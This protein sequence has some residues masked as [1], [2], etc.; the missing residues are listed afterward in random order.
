MAEWCNQ[1]LTRSK[2]SCARHDQR[3]FSHQ[4]PSLMRNVMKGSSYCTLQE[5]VCQT[6]LFSIPDKASNLHQ[7]DEQMSEHN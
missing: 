4:A 7:S 5:G 3:T 6:R 1:V 2:A